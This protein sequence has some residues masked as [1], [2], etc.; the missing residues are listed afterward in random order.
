MST[1]NKFT[2]LALALPILTMSFMAFH[3]GTFAVIAA[4]RTKRIPFRFVT[5]AI[6]CIIAVV[7][8]CNDAIIGIIATIIVADLIGVSVMMGRL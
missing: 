5:V 8:V 7:V 4:P 6:I 1:F 3:L 2:A